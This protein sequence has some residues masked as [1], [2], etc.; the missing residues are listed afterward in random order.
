MAVSRTGANLNHVKK[1]E[2]LDADQI[3]RDT[4]IDVNKKL[5]ENNLVFTVLG[6]STE[7]GVGS[8]G[9]VYGQCNDDRYAGF[10]NIIGYTLITNDSNFVPLNP[11]AKSIYYAYD[12]NKSAID[13]ICPSW[14]FIVSDNE[15][16]NCNIY[17]NNRSG[18]DKLTIYHNQRTSDT[19]ARIQ[20][21]V[22]TSNNLTTLYQG[23]IDSYHGVETFN[24]ITDGVD[25]R[26]AKTTVTLSSSTE[27]QLNITLDSPDVIDRGSGVAGNG[28]IAICGF[29][30][31][32]GVEFHN[33]AVSSTTLKDESAANISRGVTTSERLALAQSYNANMFYIGFGTNDSKDGISDVIT[34]KAEYEALIDNIRAEEPNAVII[35]GTDPAGSGV[36]VNNVD[37]NTVIRE[38]AVNKGCFLF[39]VEKIAETSPSSFYYDDVHPS[40]VGNTILAKAFESQFGL[41]TPS[42]STSSIAPYSDGIPTFDGKC[43]YLALTESVYD[44]TGSWVEV[45]SLVAIT[46]PNAV[47]IELRVDVVVARSSL[48]LEQCGIRLK[49]AGT[50]MD[51]KIASFPQVNGLALGTISAYRLYEIGGAS[52]YTI[53]VDMKNFLIRSS[54][55]RSYISYRWI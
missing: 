2:M 39:D 7:A 22:K 37:Y 32:S 35:L 19:A 12:G 1:H 46:P 34:F 17:N 20:L 52:E 30:F 44:Y 11:L 26:L 51:E 53:S 24:T 14:Q 38:V 49:L 4:K 36:Y 28:T 13:M 50:I 54:D 55:A 9:G 8:G 40:Y 15:S 48:D 3:L 10:L 33:L 25:G 5:A 31:G 23:M 47:G 21:T 16:V 42:I 41:K 18:S 6:D 45:G 43:G 27:R 29:A